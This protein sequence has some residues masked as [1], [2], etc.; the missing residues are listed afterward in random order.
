MSSNGG[1][2]SSTK[3]AGTGGAASAKNNFARILAKE[4][5]DVEEVRIDGLDN[6][7]S[8]FI[9]TGYATEGSLTSAAVWLVVRVSMNANENPTRI[10][11]RN[12]VVWDNRATGWS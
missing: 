10:Q 5:L 4:P 1:G 11:Y 7:V 2:I 3:L 9:Y 8:G 12:N 6:L